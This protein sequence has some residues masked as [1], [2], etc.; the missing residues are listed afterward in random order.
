MNGTLG[1]LEHL[2]CLPHCLYFLQVKEL[3]EFT[4][5]TGLEVPFGRTQTQE[6]SP[7]IYKFSDARKTLVPTHLK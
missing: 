1:F 4:L 2:T 5:A 6:T 7:G 3:S